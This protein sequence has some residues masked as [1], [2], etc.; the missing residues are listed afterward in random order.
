MMR[1]AILSAAVCLIAATGGCTPTDERDYPSLLPR[2]IER[3]SDAEPITRA[4]IAAPDPA[5][6]AKIGGIRIA[7]ADAARAFD[8]ASASA[9]ALARAARGASAGSDAWLDA[10]TALAGLDGHRAE[11][12]AALSDL[13]QLAI[14]RAAAGQ[15]DYPAIGTAQIAA[16]TQ[17]DSQAA[18]I[19]RLQAMLAPA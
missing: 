10:Q 3:R 2:P 12:S 11:T 16:Q 15:P 18:A 19:A 6:D 1:V 5:L 8:Q 17:I 4:Q 7:L 13:E 9:D 14:D